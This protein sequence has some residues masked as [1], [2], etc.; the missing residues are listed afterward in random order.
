MI[1][2]ITVLGGL[3]KA[4]QEEDIEK[5]AISKGEILSIVGF[6]GSGKSQ[7]ISDVG[8]WAA[9]ETPSKRTVLINNM[10]AYE[11]AKQS[12]LR[13][14]V[15]EVSQNMNFVIDMSVNDF[16]HLHAKSRQ[17]QQ[18]DDLVKEVIDCAN[19]LT[20][21]PIHSED[22]LTTLSGGQ[23]RS[24]MVADV[25]LI[26]NAPVVL[27]DEIENAGINRLEAL[28]FLAVQGKVVMVVTHDPVLALMADKRVIME[29]GG[30]SKLI[31]TTEEEKKAL[32]ELITVDNFLS[33]LRE[34]LRGGQKIKTSMR[35]FG[36]KKNKENNNNK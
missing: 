23:S 13:H 21:E 17:L 27:I 2:K 32:E 9:G 24:L 20:G 28:K 12:A 1:E 14:M 16:L 11:Y 36:Q 5:L 33:S 35:I 29:K 15:A 22:N 7:L 10:P 18:R 25:A 30:M 26:S 3:N 8:Q 4:R 31:I 6:T 34:K 19:K